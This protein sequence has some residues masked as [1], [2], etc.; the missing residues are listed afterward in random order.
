MYQVS[1]HQDL[2]MLRPIGATI[3][4]RRSAPGYRLV[5]RSRSSTGMPIVETPPLTFAS[6]EEA[7][8]HARMTYGIAHCRAEAMVAAVP[9]QRD[10]G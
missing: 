2:F 4:E 7:A 10:V 5:L 3:V 6:V 1:E 8:A 9:R